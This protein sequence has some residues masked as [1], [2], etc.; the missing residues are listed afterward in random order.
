[1]F[2]YCTCI[3]DTFRHL[4]TFNAM[5]VGSR[6]TLTFTVRMRGAIKCA[7]LSKKSKWRFKYNNQ[8]V[9]IHGPVMLDTSLYCVSCACIVVE[10]RSV[11][12]SK[13]WG[14]CWGFGMFTNLKAFTPEGISIGKHPALQASFANFLREIT[15]VLHLHA[16][17]RAKIGPASHFPEGPSLVI[18]WSLLWAVWTFRQAKYIS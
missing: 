6:S 16:P 3:L 7:N 13:S 14:K 18:Q 1:M 5:P 2:F 17:L 15:E 12:Y 11:W 10:T 4:Y 9:P 8:Y